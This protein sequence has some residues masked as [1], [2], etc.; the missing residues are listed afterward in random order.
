MENQWEKGDIA[1]P[2]T[3]NIGLPGGLASNPPG[4]TWKQ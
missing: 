1:V 3:H 2:G 4:R